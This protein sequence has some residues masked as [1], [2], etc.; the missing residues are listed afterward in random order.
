[1][2]Y[3]NSQQI[4]H[5]ISGSHLKL[6]FTTQ[7][8]KAASSEEQKGEE[9]RDVRVDIEILKVDDNKH[10]VKFSYKDPATKVDLG[11]SRDIIQH[12]MSIRDA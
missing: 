4:A 8:A 7:L 6:N 10:C 2:T 12:F 9:T 11:K 5:R 1:M 3:L